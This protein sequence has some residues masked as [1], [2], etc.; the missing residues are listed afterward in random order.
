MRPTAGMMRG[1]GLGWS[2]LMGRRILLLQANKFP[3]GDAAVIC[4]L[5][6]LTR[7]AAFPEQ[8]RRGGGQMS[9]FYPAF[10]RN[11]TV[12]T[13]TPHWAAPCALVSGAFLLSETP[14]TSFT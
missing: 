2:G 4:G 6:R 9:M 7:L 5:K 12:N 8:S 13:A 3:S 1:W 10:E 11:L 14:C